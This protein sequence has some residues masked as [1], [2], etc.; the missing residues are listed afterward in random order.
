MKNIATSLALAAL[1]A[2]CSKNDE[3]TG[4]IG[5]SESGTASNRY[6]L[7]VRTDSGTSDD[8]HARAKWLTNASPAGAAADQS[9]DQTKE[10]D[11]TGQ[12]KRDREGLTLTPL[13]Q[14][15][16]QSDR[17]ITQAIRKS[18]VIEPGKDEH[19]L[20]AK[21]IKIITLNGTV[22]LRGVVRTDQEKSDIEIR[23]RQTPGVTKVD[24]QL[25]VKP[26]P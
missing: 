21:N 18:I 3:G 20:A 7:R 17:E 26:S 10:A 22:T 4:T 19:S 13:D 8:M 16:S 14:G 15:S 2:G 11:N 25:E 23:A 6:Q 5:Y 9:V 1:L 24:N 12:N